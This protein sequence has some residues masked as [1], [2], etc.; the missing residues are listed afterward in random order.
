MY[1]KVSFLQHHFASSGSGHRP[2]GGA[3]VPERME[4]REHDDDEAQTGHTP[5][6]GQG[7]ERMKPTEPGPPGPV[8][9]DMYVVSEAQCGSRGGLISLPI[10][11]QSDPSCAAP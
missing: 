3:A 6:I 7:G 4:G 1:L 2:A 5:V 11:F 8:Q 9:E 10:C